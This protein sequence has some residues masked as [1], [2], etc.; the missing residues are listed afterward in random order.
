MRAVILGL[1]LV[2]VVALPIVISSM[3]DDEPA[4]A[5]VPVVEIDLAQAEQRIQ[6][7]IDS[8]DLAELCEPLGRQ[9]SEQAEGLLRRLIDGSPNRRVRGLATLQLAM[10]YRSRAKQS[11]SDDLMRS[12]RAWFKNVARDYADIVSEGDLPPEVVADLDRGTTVGKVAIEISGQDI[13][14]AHF[15]LSDYRG[16]VV[17]LDFWGDW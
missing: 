17:V 10:S 2:C 5:E 4:V 12:A 14:G 1:G 13:D 7:E 15:K 6:N 9:A 3:R 16:K 11:G 8:A